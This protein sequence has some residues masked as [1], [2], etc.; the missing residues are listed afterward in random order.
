MDIS[1][2]EPLVRLSCFAGVLLVMAMWEALAPRR[3]LTTARPLR[4]ASNL[5]LSALNTLAVRF[6]IPLG[7]VDTAPLAQEHGWGLLN[8]VTLP[9]WL[10]VVLAVVALDFVIYLQHVL[11][12]AVPALWRRAERLHWMLALPF[13]G[14]T[15]E[16]PV[17][18]RGPA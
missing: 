4:W 6:L 14:E 8:A 11:F 18:R 17:N 7:A 1:A 13:V 9:D 16:Y 12:H 5:G 2:N 15:G 10:K 3:R